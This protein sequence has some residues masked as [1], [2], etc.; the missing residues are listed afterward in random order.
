MEEW[1]GGIDGT[2][3]VTSID[4]GKQEMLESGV[5]NHQVSPE[6]EDGTEAPQ[7]RVNSVHQAIAIL[8]YLELQE[9]AIGVNGIA[10]ALDISPSSCFNLLKTLVEEQFA[11]F[12]R[13]S[14]LYSLGPGAAVLGRRALDPAGALSLI[15][16]RLEALADRH[17]V[18]ASLWRMRR[19]RQLILVGFAESDASFRV[20]LATGQ[21]IPSGSG[22]AGR[23]VMA[24]SELDEAAIR[25][26]Y[27]RVNWGVAPD[28]A[29][30][31]AEVR[32]TRAHRWAIDTGNLISGVTSVAAPCLNAAEVPEYVI[33]A[34]MFTGQHSRDRLEAI[35]EDVRRQAEWLATRLFKGSR[36]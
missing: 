15:R 12:D 6:E 27:D 18:T 35:A 23:C 19:G 9:R 31:L 10:R 14:K 21:Q 28:F 16:P 24:F 17:S 3:L 13:S 4:M 1:P 32:A 33:T 22:A 25:R 8:R 29:T 20:H 30:Y 34:T 36:P 5:T 26:R 11:D 7:R 2:R